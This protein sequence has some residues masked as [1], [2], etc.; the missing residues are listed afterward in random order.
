M[1]QFSLLVILLVLLLAG[2]ESDVTKNEIN[3]A[4]LEMV[5]VNGGTFD[6]GN[7]FGE[8]N[9]NE[10]PVHSVNLSSFYISNLEVT[11]KQYKDLM[12]ALPGSGYGIGDDFPVFQVPWDK[13]LEFCNLLSIQEGFTPCYNMADSTCNWSA[14]GYRL[15][16]EAEWEFAAKAG[17]IDQEFPFSGCE[18]VEDAAWYRANSD[19]QTHIVG[20][21]QPNSLGLYD[22]SGNV[23]EWCW[24]FYDEDYY[25]NSAGVNPTGPEEGLFHMGR[26]GCWYSEECSCCCT[27][28]PVSQSIGSRYIGFR[29]VRNTAGVRPWNLFLDDF[30]LK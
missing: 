5:L 28:R 14:N 29:V 9:D 2:C 6:M 17:G 7:T 23:Y 10:Y 12:G 16:T 19:N 1:K 20:T 3:G 15:P 22:M 25:G 21:K 27:N 13:A 8:G 24:D 26:G 4:T 30:E 11:Q 18:N